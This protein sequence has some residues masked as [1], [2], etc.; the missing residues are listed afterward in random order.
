MLFQF[1]LSLLLWLACRYHQVLLMV[2][3]CQAY[4]QVARITAPRV[5]AVGSSVKGVR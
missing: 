1:L 3:S 5:I 4:T 2:E